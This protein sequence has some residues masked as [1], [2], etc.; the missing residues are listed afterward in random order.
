MQMSQSD[1]S[2]ILPVLQHFLTLRFRYSTF[3][4]V[5]TGLTYADYVW[6]RQKN[7]KPFDKNNIPDWYQACPR[8][9]EDKGDLYI[10]PEE[11]VYV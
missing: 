11:Y 2:H 4:R 6:I 7:W 3:V 8:Q 10:E 5:G 1:Y 9:S